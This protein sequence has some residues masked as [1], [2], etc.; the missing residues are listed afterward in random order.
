MYTVATA[1]C[2]DYST[3]NL[4]QAISNVLSNIIDLSTLIKPGT[5]VL[6]KPNIVTGTPP[7]RAITTHPEFVYAVGKLIKSFG[8]ELWIG[9]SPVI[10]DSYEIAKEAGIIDIV[11]KLDAKY[12]SFNTPVSVEFTEGKIAKYFLME[13]AV[14][15]ADVII[16]IPK[17][18][19]HGF[20]FLSAASKNLYGCLFEKT[21]GHI[22]MPSRDLF[23]KMI[24][25]LNQIIVPQINIVDG[26]LAMEGDGPT[27][28]IPRQANII[29]A[30]TNAF[31][32]DAVVS[33]VIGLDPKTVPFLSEAHNQKLVDLDNIAI[34]GEPIENIKID[35]YKLIEPVTSVI[36]VASERLKP[37]L[38]EK[39]TMVKDNCKL[40]QKCIKICPMKAIT[41]KDKNLIFDYYKCIYCY[42]CQEVCPHG[43]IDLKPTNTFV[44]I[45]LNLVDKYLY[46][47][48]MAG[49]KLLRPFRK[50]YQ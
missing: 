38:L 17:L 33:K 1:K 6:L 21:K 25:D 10:G 26:I 18:K 40:C 23:S 12:V 7:S 42:C 36:T 2:P 5:K 32:T 46:P 47:S 28:G 3:Q 49:K 39:P 44:R 35:D 34:K 37:Y 30:G 24:V 16:N 15:D 4:E 27:N 8:A 20:V 43:G 29:I 11:E 19:T 48:Y 13:K 31:A 50:E 41:L 45:V 22:Q 9:D 14:F